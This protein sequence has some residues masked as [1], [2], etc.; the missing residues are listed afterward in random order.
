VN[1]LLLT[2]SGA[3][4]D[5]KAHHSRT[6]LLFVIKNRNIT[7]IYLLLANSITPDSM[8][9]KYKQTLLLLAAK[10]GRDIIMRLFLFT[11]NIDPKSWDSNRIILLLLAAR[12]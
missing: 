4:P 8:D 10:Y 2:N 12:E 9:F 7:I 5:S 11:D 1:L 3:N 6:P